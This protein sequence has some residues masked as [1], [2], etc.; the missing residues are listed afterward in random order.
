MNAETTISSKGQIVI[1]KDVRDRL[2]L[3]PGMSLEV[4]ETAGGLFLKIAE[5]TQ[6]R[7]FNECEAL[8]RKAINY[9]G[10]RYSDNEEKAA[11]AEMFKTSHKFDRQ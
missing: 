6:K 3:E 11:I 4:I 1:P 2:K 10:P 5:R 8:I 9:R 7:D